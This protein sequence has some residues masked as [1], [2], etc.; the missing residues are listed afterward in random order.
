MTEEAKVKCHSCKK[1]LEIDVNSRISL[2]EECEYCYADL[3]VCKMCE[4]F[5]PKVYNECRET[6]AERI[7]EKDKKNFCGYFKL[8]GSEDEDMKKRN[9]MD[10]ANSLFKD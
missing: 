4:F 3:H 1:E 6:N 7:V 9:L 2:S 5:D 10:A 8:T